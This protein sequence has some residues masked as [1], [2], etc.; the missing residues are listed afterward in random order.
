MPNYVTINLEGLDPK[1]SVIYM[2]NRGSYYATA[3]GFGSHSHMMTL[4]DRV[5][6]PFFK[7]CATCPY[8]KIYQKTGN[9][10]VG[11]PGG[12]R[13]LSGSGY[14]DTVYIEGTGHRVPTTA[15]TCR[16]IIAKEFSFKPFAE[17]P[18][19]VKLPDYILVNRRG[20]DFD[21]SY[22][23]R[24]FLAKPDASQLSDLYKGIPFIFGNVHHNGS[25]CLGS[26]RSDVDWNKW[27]TI[28]NAFL[29][30]SRN[31]DWT[32]YWRENNKPELQTL[33]DYAARLNNE[34]ASFVNQFQ[35]DDYID[36]RETIFQ[37]FRYDNKFVLPYQP[38]FKN[39]KFDKYSDTFFIELDNGTL[40][41]TDLTPVQQAENTDVDVEF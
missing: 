35:Y 4:L 25:V 31:N 17:T 10:A 22:K 38:N 30:F 9:T 23:L 3:L 2:A 28:Q 21:T 27:S 11:C 36:W 19:A 6:A 24:A 20:Y 7:H 14:S 8:N 26:A 32:E 5:N 12:I 37:G 41:N 40:L 33:V 1:P 15:K 16:R 34:G 13:Y 39:I 29:N 18:Y